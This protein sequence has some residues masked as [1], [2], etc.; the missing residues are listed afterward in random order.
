[1]NKELKEIEK[2]KIKQ[3]GVFKEESN[4]SFK[5][6]EECTIK[7]VKETNTTV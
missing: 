6:L 2:N 3:R 4:E 7:Q 5:D 1:M